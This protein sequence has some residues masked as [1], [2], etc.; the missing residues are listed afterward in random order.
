MSNF[1]LDII[2]FSFQFTLQT[3]NSTC[4]SQTVT[5]ATR[6]WQIVMAYISSM[7]PMFIYVI[8]ISRVQSQ[9]HFELIN[10]HLYK[11]KKKQ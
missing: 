2:F 3:L 8:I 9:I 11:V 6:W 10:K 1:L 4:T 5:L 7:R